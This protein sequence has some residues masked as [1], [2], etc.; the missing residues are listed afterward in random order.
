[1]LKLYATKYAL[2]HVNNVALIYILHYN[3]ITT[4]SEHTKGQNL[5]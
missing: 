5:H 4:P 2:K 1:M 3:I